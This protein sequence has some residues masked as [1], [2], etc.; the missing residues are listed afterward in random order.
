MVLCL[1]PL[2]GMTVLVHTIVGFS[3]LPFGWRSCKMYINVHIYR[4]VCMYPGCQFI[5]SFIGRQ[6]CI[7][8]ETFLSFP[9]NLKIICNSC[10]RKQTI[11]AVSGFQMSVHF[12]VETDFS[13]MFFQNLRFREWNISDHSYYLITL[14]LFFLLSKPSWLWQIIGHC[15]SCKTGLDEFAG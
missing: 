7:L 12:S 5:N 11:L 4:C 10:S 14:F 3:S 13:V 2:P 1:V 8:T 6:I 9:R 15:W